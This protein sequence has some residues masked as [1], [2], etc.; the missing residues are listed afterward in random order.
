MLDVNESGIWIA[1]TG[2][3]TSFEEIAIMIAEKYESNVNRIPM[4]EELKHQYQEYTCANLH[5]LN[6]TVKMNWF[7]VEDYINY[8]L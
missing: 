2:V 3:A 1:G 6:S 4:P 8:E 7:P 5:K